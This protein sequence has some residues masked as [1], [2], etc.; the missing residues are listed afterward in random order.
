MIIES[1][2]NC[3]IVS[4]TQLYLF[5]YEYRWWKNKH[6][7][8]NI[9]VFVRQGRSWSG[10]VQRRIVRTLHPF[11]TP[12]TTRY[13]VRTVGVAQNA[14]SFWQEMAS[15]VPLLKHVVN[16]VIEL[17]RR[18]QRGIQKARKLRQKEKRKKEKKRR[19]D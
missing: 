10:G 2:I 4:T 14:R 8:T 13:E 9:R 1:T 12:I 18:I 11:L 17:I 16:I 6:P 5:D 15:Q 7:K 3:I 19:E